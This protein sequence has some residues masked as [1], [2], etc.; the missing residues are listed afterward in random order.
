MR[1]KQF[2]HK[3]AAGFIVITLVL[4]MIGCAGTKKFDFGSADTG[5]ILTYRAA[6]EAVMKY[7]TTQNMVILQEIMGQEMEVVTERVMDYS[8]QT[9]A[10]TTKGEMHFSLT[11]DKFTSQSK[12]P[13]GEFSVDSEELIGKSVKIGIGAHGDVT[14]KSGFD[15]LPKITMAGQD[16][17]LEE[18]FRELLPPLAAKP[19]KI[20]ATWEKAR[21]DTTAAGP[22][23]III[24]S[25]N[26][27][28]LVEEIEMNGQ[29]C[30]KI[31]AESVF[32]V[33][34]EG[35]QGGADI[36]FEGD[37]E[38]TEEIIFAYQAGTLLKRTS[39]T[40]IEG[41]A[42]VTGAANMTIPMTQ[43]IKESIELLP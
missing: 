21:T 9:E 40:L 11:F 25:T 13:Q 26:T 4:L 5:F 16:V 6:K 23:D 8:M 38:G 7:H 35:S 32:T 20:G 2:Q 34:G 39:D 29:A 41:T 30:L 36:V 14:E 17:N 22:M 10:I 28:T 15:E 12:S 19:V 3:G 42:M 37:G 1:N 33:G 24:E 27:Y 18:Q 31:K 43:E